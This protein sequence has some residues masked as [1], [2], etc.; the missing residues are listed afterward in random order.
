MTKFK[1]LVLAIAML[2]LAGCEDSKTAGTPTFKGTGSIYIFNAYQF[3]ANLTKWLADNKHARL[4]SIEGM[5][6]DGGGNP[7]KYVVVVEYPPEY[8]PPQPP[9]PDP[10]ATKV[11]K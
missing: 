2:L 4:V 11:E 7:Q 1:I 8:I 10:N 9:P 6:H 5:N 3:H